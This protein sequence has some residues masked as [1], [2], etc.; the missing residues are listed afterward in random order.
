M[1]SR[2]PSVDGRKRLGEYQVLK[3]IGE[4]AFGHVKLAI[5][6][7]TGQKVA[8]KYF[9][10]AR[11][12]NMKLGARVTRE[13][14][15]LRLLDHPHIV[16]IY[17][18]INTPA[19]IIMVIEFAGAELFDTLAKHGRLQEETARSIFQQLVSAVAHSHKC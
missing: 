2:E 14:Q 8:L 15:Y 7:L 12:K 9:S 17:E 1:S 11:I 5:H 4:G 19:D 3:N 6:S 10:K 16:K 13:I 18:V